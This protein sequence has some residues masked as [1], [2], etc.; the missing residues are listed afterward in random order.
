MGPTPI[1]TTFLLA[2]L[3]AVALLET[4]AAYLGTRMQ[5]PRLWL[6]AGTRTA[7]ML[8][9]I[10]LAMVQGG[11]PQVLGLDRH[12]LQ[13]GFRKGPV[14][15]LWACSWPAWTRSRWFDHR[16]RK[17]HTNGFCFF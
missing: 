3:L 14:C 1:S 4:A 2:S 6:I 15:C 17:G 12:T 9:V 7:Q 5:L 13:S 8:V 11:G 10:I 16:C